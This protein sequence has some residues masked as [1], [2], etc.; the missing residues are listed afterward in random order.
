M[1]PE[2]DLHYD[3]LGALTRMGLRTKTRRFK[4]NEM[5]Y[6]QGDDAQ[7]VFYLEQGRVKITVASR[8]GKEAV[9]ALLDADNFF[10]EGCLNGQRLRLSTATALDDC[11]VISLD[12]RTMRQA[13][14]EEERF[15]DR[16][17]SH[18]LARNQRIEEDL[19]DQLF[20]SSEK[21]LA[22][23]LLLLANFGKEGRL[24]PVLPKISQTT[25]AEMVGTTRP[26]VNQFMNKFRDLGFIDY[27]DTLEV[28]SSLLNVILND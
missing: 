4:A 6:S 18:L 12:K 25:L 24:E 3:V 10:G 27:N 23:I 2:K 13:M 17:L 20:N 28:H 22:R 8:S 14:H 19:V 7:D 1:K 16:F 21:R 11:T 9:L 15:S 5:I 26:R